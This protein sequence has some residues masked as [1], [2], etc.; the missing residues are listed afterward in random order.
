MRARKERAP[1]RM[2]VQDRAGIHAARDGEMQQGF[3]RRAAF[4][5][6]SISRNCS[7]ARLPLSKPVEVIARRSGSREITALKFPLVPKTHPRAWK[8]LTISD[9]RAATSAKRVPLGLFRGFAFRLFLRLTLLLVFF[10]VAPL[11]E[12]SRS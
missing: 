8:P 5:A 10:I 9:R 4:A 6:P 2:S 11:L 1:N 7:G 3:R 12:I